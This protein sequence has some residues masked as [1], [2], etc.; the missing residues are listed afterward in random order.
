MEH[1]LPVAVKTTSVDGTVTLELSGVLDEQ[2]TFD[3]VVIPEATT[4]VFNLEGLRGINSL[5]IRIWMAF[6]ARLNGSQSQFKFVRCSDV[7]IEQL[8]MMTNFLPERTTIESLYV[9][10]VCQQ[11]R[12]E[13][14]VLTQLSGGE[15]S[16]QEDVTC[17]VCQQ[18]MELDE[19]MSEFRVVMRKLQEGG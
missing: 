10:Y 6:M 15:L 18:K 11:C 3:R 9:P 12:V 2:T 7:F 17:E 4:V 8:V 13:R 19:L 5:G 14:I 16:T 1:S